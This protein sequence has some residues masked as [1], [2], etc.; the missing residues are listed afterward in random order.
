MLSSFCRNVVCVLCLVFRVGFEEVVFCG[1]VV[2]VCVLIWCFF[3]VSRFLVWGGNLEEGGE[4]FLII[5]VV[6]E[7]EFGGVRTFL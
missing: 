7:E 3:R 4:F 6:L 5:G 2:F 1:F